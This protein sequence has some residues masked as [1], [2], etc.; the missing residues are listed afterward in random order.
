MPMLGPISYLLR[1]PSEDSSALAASLHTFLEQLP[2]F[3]FLTSAKFTK[4]GLQKVINKYRNGGVHDSPVSE[5]TCR[6]CLDALMGT[7]G[8]SGFISLV[9][10]WKKTNTNE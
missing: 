5:E 7:Q 10:S 1:K 9:S 2:N 4:R 8:I 3:D 6:K